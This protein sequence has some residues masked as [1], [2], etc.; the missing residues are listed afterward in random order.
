MQ[1]SE[2]FL[3]EIFH[4]L[5]NELNVNAEGTELLNSFI[6]SY[7]DV[8]KFLDSPNGDCTNCGQYPSNQVVE[9][10]IE[11]R[12]KMRNNILFLYSQQHSQPYI[13]MTNIREIP[14]EIF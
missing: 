9:E 11:R 8:G 12:I 1:D 5:Q 14:G 2:E 6:G 4:I 10:R 7:V 13:P 3:R